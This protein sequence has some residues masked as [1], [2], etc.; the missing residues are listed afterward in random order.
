MKLER[1]TTTS[2]RIFSTGHNV[3]LAYNIC[4]KN[5]VEPSPDK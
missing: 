5:T 4:Q 2:T 1:I 3:Q